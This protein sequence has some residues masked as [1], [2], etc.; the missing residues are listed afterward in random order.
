MVYIKFK[1]NFKLIGI[2]II[3]IHVKTKVNLDTNKIEM[4]VYFY[5]NK[6]CL[7]AAGDVD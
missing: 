5:I 6:S 2:H 3:G 4:F 7:I 1:I